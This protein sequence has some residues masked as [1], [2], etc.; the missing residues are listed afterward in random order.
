MSLRMIA[1]HAAMS[2]MRRANAARRTRAAERGEPIV[3]HPD[4]PTAAL[5]RRF[6]VTR[7]PVVPPDAA[8]GD[9]GDPV[10]RLVP[11]TGAS[12]AQ[13]VYLHGGSF[14][15]PLRAWHWNLLDRATRGT[16]AAISVPLYRLAPAGDAARGVGFVREVVRRLADAG[17]ADRI[18]LAGDSAGGGLALATALALR[19]DGIRVA[20]LSLASPWVDVAVDDPAS[21]ALEGSDAILRVGPLQRAG[22]LWAGGLDVRDPRVSPL[23]GELHD[24]PPVDV[25]WGADEVLA[26]DIA[27]LAAKL[28]AA[29]NRGTSL[30]EPGAVHGYAVMTWTPEGRRAVERLRGRLAALA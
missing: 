10:I 9:G 6:D 4:A 17:G 12:R 28:D 19:D 14:L 8:P 27:R 29:G 26:P 15:H 25:T 16:G 11:R 2:A 13:L 22:R 24:L 7:W 30:A 20:R 5:R 21:R 23:H 3:E 18:V 1:T